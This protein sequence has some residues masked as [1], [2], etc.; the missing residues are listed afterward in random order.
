M[1][2][3]FDFDDV[4][5]DNVSFKKKVFSYFEKYGLS[6]EVCESLYKKHRAYFSLRKLYDEVSIYTGKTFSQNEFAI[7]REYTFS[8]FDTYLNSNLVAIIE[9]V[10]K[11]NC[12]ILTAGDAQF[13]NEK[14]I[15]SGLITHIHKEHILIVKDDKKES[16]LSLCTLHKDEIFV[17]VDDKE[18]HIQGA[19]DLHLS[20]LHVVLYDSNGFTR[21]TN[22]IDSQ[23][24][25]GL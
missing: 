18:K 13:Q 1:K 8:N 14:I 9:K 25:S 12:F 6:S 21:L 4:L 19:I 3:I 2:I 24:E 20:N 10:G 5:F 22:I 15:E 17:F 7:F 11:E 16:L 23:I